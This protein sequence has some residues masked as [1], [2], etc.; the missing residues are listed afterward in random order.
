MQNIFLR[1]R[2]QE[3]LQSLH[4]V[5]NTKKDKTDKGYKIIPFINHL[6]ESFKVVFSNKPEQSVDKHMTKFKGRSSMR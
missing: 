6:N 1:T 3:V 4:F 5:D 2:Y